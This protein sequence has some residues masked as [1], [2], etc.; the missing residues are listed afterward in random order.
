MHRTDD[1][2]QTEINGYKTF[3]D[4][5]EELPRLSILDN[6]KQ[7]TRIL[8]NQYIRSFDEEK[9]FGNRSTTETNETEDPEYL[10]FKEEK[11]NTMKMSTILKNLDSPKKKRKSIAALRQKKA[12]ELKM[13]KRSRTVT[14]FRTIL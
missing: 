4:D 5:K 6:Y 10:R 11:S 7:I 14:Q 12:D 8:T 13:S 1:K 2:F 9:I 3:L